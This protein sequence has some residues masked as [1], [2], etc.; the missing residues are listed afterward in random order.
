M[1]EALLR[2]A[3]RAPEPPTEKQATLD[4]DLGAHCGGCH[5]SGPRAFPRDGAL[6]RELLQ[7]MLRQV[8]FG[9]M[10]RAPAEMDAAA[11]RVMVREI[12]AAL[13]DDEG[14]R[15]E[16][17]RYFDGGMRGMR[18]HRGTAILGLVEQRAG[19]HDEEATSWTFSDADRHDAAELGPSFAATFALAALRACKAAGVRGGALEACVTRALDVEAAVKAAPR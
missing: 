19:G 13:W 1:R 4:Q 17:A 5:G 8:A 11:R 10:P 9:D 6:P 15:R 16:A 7:K 12:I 14:S 3:R 18:V 2:F